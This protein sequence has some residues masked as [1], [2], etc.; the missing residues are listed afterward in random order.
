MWSSENC[1][2]ITILKSAVQLVQ[3]RITVKTKS[4]ASYIKMYL[5]QREYSCFEQ[6][7]EIEREGKNIFFRRKMSTNLLDNILSLSLE[8]IAAYKTVMPAKMIRS[9]YDFTGKGNKGLFFSSKVI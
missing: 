6:Q 3:S 2:S 4:F 7:T 9:L 5:R 1:K 8:N